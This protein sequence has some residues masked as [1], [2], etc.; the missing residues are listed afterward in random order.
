MSVTT[1]EM[2][3]GAGN[4]NVNSSPPPRR[5]L[6]A[7][8]TNSNIIASPLRLASASLSLSR[9]FT[10]QRMKQFHQPLPDFFT[11]NTM[12]SALRRSRRAVPTKT[13]NYAVGDIVEVR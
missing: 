3:A 11:T 10:T 7:F 12:T 4:V 1:I 9:V 2:L 5:S 6:R 13:S 8:C